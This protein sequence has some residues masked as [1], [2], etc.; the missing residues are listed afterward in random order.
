MKVKLVCYL[1]LGFQFVSMDIFSLLYFSV[2]LC[3]IGLGGLFSSAAKHKEGE[4]QMN[5]QIGHFS[6]T[7]IAV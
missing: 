4:G 7:V 3:I 5:C 1:N 2:Q 6:T